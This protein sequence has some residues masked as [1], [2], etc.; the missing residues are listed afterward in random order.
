[1]SSN[2]HQVP[3]GLWCMFVAGGDSGGMI[4]DVFYLTAANAIESSSTKLLAILE[5]LLLPLFR[6][7]LSHFRALN[8]GKHS[9]PWRSLLVF[10]L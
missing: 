1:M 6:S 3:R 2:R 7:V 10:D 9:E 5:I 4:C 8:V